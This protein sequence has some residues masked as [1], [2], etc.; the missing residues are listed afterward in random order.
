MSSFVILHERGIPVSAPA[1]TD[2][3]SA[4]D[5]AHRD[6]G[7]S[8][9]TSCCPA[10]DLIAFASSNQLVV[11]RSIKWETLF[12]SSCNASAIAWRPDGKALAV[13]QGD[14]Q[15]VLFDVENGE[16][17]SL[18]RGARPHSAAI[19]CM[20]WSKAGC[21]N[22][23]ITH[24]PVHGSHSRYRDRSSLLLPVRKVDTEAHDKSMFKSH[25]SALMGT[26]LFGVDSA[27]LTELEVLI[28]GDNAG[29]VTMSAFGYFSIGCVDLSG[30][31]P[32][33]PRDA[34][35]RVCK[36][37]L[38]EDLSM[39]LAVLECE[40]NVRIVTV[41][42]QILSSRAD[43]L[44]HVA[45]QCGHVSESLAS[46]QDAVDT[47]SKVWTEGIGALQKHIE[48]LQH[49]LRNF[50]RP[51]TA[52]QE[53]FMMLTCGVTSAALQHY[54]ADLREPQLR[55]LGKT[56]DDTCSRMNAIAAET[57]GHAAQA[58][59][60]RL[61]DLLGLA[62]W[63]EKFSLIGLNK[64]VL[65]ALLDRSHALLLK[66]QEIAIL[67]QEARANF[68]AFSTWLQLVWSKNQKQQPGEAGAT[69][70]K[71]L[72]Q[73]D[74]DR[75]VKLFSQQLLHDHI[76]EQFKASSLRLAKPPSVWTSSTHASD[77]TLSL[78]QA[79][80][81]T[82]SDW[83]AAFHMT[84]EKVS[85]AFRPVENHPIDDV[86]QRLIDIRS[87]GE[88]FYVVIGDGTNT[89]RIG[90]RSISNGSGD[91][92]K[93]S[94]ISVQDAAAIHDVRFYNADHLLLTYTSQDQER[95]VGQFA[96]K[97]PSP[98]GTVSRSRVLKPQ[99]WQTSGLECQGKRGIMAVFTS[100]RQLCVLDVEDDEDDEEDEEDEEQ[101]DDQ[102]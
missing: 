7:E 9:I 18:P 21:D 17:L 11:T 31:F 91:S 28:S 33:R 61:H 102:D 96:F 46:I 99:S 34:P 24:G 22:K 43:E 2:S 70:R 26:P 29:I 1:A 5:V 35:L 72:I 42:T 89:V 83:A 71:H 36:A 66:A 25:A 69:S 76:T 50:D 74:I 27:P 62:E 67:V 63:K 32:K 81:A 73:V 41:D 16:E 68:A 48:P 10:M 3:S 39:L 93:F 86:E 14:G 64:K 52:E 101:D 19:T 90:S 58:L 45:A 82:S 56:L 97:D 77:N 80:E 13:G 53:L 49:Q 23:V 75:L 4:S 15:I 79:L 55:K 30:A 95:F 51:N 65:K 37:R 40:S 12:R 84:S 47:M 8:C 98:T 59:V 85:A 100:N 87:D 20:S 57:L 94:S 78:R 6:G 92:L 60:F 38:S 54:I 88:M 44:Q